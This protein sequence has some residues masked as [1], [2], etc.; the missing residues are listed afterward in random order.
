LSKTT[1]VG[2]LVAGLPTGL[3][4]S[5]KFGEYVAADG[6]DQITSIE[7]HDCGIVYYPPSPYFI[8]VMTRGTNLDNLKTAIKDVSGLIYDKIS[9]QK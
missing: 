6:N 4:V 2:G 9:N 7:L 1:F 3:T 8:C 5:H